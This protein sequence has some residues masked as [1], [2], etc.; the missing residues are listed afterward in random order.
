[1]K[2][3]L[4]DEHKLYHLA[5]AESIVDHKWDRVIFAKNPPQNKY[6]HKSQM[7]LF[8]VCQHWL[9]LHVLHYITMAHHDRC[10][11]KRVTALAEKRGL[12]ASTA[13]E[14]WISHVC[15]KG[16]AIQILEGWAG[17]KA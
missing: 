12:P 1:L 14:L 2:E 10:I 4:T 11:C 9:K 17:W 6:C 16:M 3:L 7:P 13:G 8:T 5:F 15:C